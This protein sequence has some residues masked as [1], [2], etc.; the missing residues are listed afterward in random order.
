[1]EKIIIQANGFVLNEKMRKHVLQ[2]L[3]SI[4]G[5]NKYEVQRIVIT[6]FDEKE[7][8]NNIESRCNIEVKIKDQPAIIT[9]L[10]SF[11]IFMATTLAIERAHLKTSRRVIDEKAIRKQIERSKN[12][13]SF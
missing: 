8:S 6:F 1:M 3:H 4:F 5:F 7:Y 10:V 13:Y 12:V 11:D 9:E 2:R